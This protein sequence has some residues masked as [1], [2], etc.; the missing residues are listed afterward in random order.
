MLSS[1]RINTNDWAAFGLWM[2][3]ARILATCGTDQVPQ[4]CGA[5][6]P[7]SFKFVQVV[8][9]WPSACQAKEFAALVIAI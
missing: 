7:P 1:T 2:P 6:A 4:W 8:H 3:F 5:S 9:S